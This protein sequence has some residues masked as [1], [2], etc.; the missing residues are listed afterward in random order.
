MPT[1]IRL[2]TE[3]DAGQILAIYGPF[4]YTPVS[5]EAEP[6]SEEEMRQRIAALSGKLPWLVCADGGKVLGYAYASSHRA[7]AAYQWSVEVSAYVADGMHRRGIGRSLYTA[8]FQSLSLQGYVNAFA[9][10]TLPNPASVGLHEAVGFT[11]V[12]VYRGVGYKLGTWHDV[13]WWERPL[14]EREREPPPPLE[15]RQVCETVA[16][17]EAM[18]DGASLLR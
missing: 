8:L 7:R 6:P 1:T 17:A 3:A 9:G 2:A 16:R 14:R 10:I 15:L 13:G 12:G 4:C 5:F 11:P 18:S